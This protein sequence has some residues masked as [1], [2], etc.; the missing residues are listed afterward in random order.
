MNVE[1]LKAELHAK[2]LLANAKVCEERLRTYMEAAW[3]ILEPNRPF[4]ASWHIDYIAEYLE[5]VNRREIKRLIINIPPRCTKSLLVSVFYPTWVWTRQ[6]GHQFLTLSHSDKLALRDAV[7][8]RALMNSKWFQDRWGSKFKLRDDQ[9]TKGRYETTANGHR[10]AQGI[11][12]KV[13]GEGGDTIIIDDPHDAEEVL[14]DA[15]RENVLS[16]YD[17]SIMMRLNDQTEGA[18]VLIMQRLHEGDLTGHLLK[19]QEEESWEHLCLPMEY[20]G[21]RY[22]SVLGLDDPRKQEGELL[23]PARFPPN[24]VHSLKSRLGSYK[25][26]GQLQQRPTPAGGGILKTNWW[27]KWP[28]DA[29][30]WHG[31]PDAPPPCIYKIQCWDTAYTEK[32]E[33][34]PS[35]CTTWGVFLD[36]LDRPH[37]ILLGAKNGHWEY[38]ALRRMAREVRDFHDPDLVLIEKKASGQSLIQDL[39]WLNILP[40]DPGGKD[41]VSRAHAVSAILEAGRVWVPDT[42]WAEAV[43]SECAKFPRGEHDDY[44]DTVT[45]ALHRFMEGAWVIHPD[46]EEDEAPDEPARARR[47]Y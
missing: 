12:A 19:K 31:D 44:V 14:S 29:K 25:A 41:K 4:K 9:N 39:G 20:E 15:E 26:S 30:W 11:S 34:D 24:V 2:L 40:Y 16:A 33:N 8:S 17:G 1:A 3:P 38:P 21:P 27:K 22:V 47:Y 43:V 45:M 23:D 10:I 5:A 42:S 7:K 36:Q 13:T 18:I 32:E 37:I 28:A 35:A 6:P 46:D